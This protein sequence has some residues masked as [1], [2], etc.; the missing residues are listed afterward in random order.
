MIG[1]GK[2]NEITFEETIGDDWSRDLEVTESPLSHRSLF[3]LGLVVFLIGAIV[4]GRIL[5]LSFGDNKF[6]RARA[7]ANLNQVQKLSA[8][9]G[10]IV[11]RNGVVLAEDK[12]VFY[13][14]LEVK[15]FLR[16]KEYRQKTLDFVQQI[17]GIAEE[18][19]WKLIDDNNSGAV[20]GSIILGSE[21]SER[22][23]IE[24]ESLDLPTLNVVSGFGRLYK[25]GEIFSPIIGYTGP[26]TSDD[27]QDHPNLDG[28]DLVGKAGVEFYYDDY[29]RGVSGSVVKIRDALGN[30]LEEKKVKEPEIGQ[31]LKLTIDAELQEY[32]YNRFQSGLRSLGR[33]VGVG[34][35]INPQNGE[36]LSLINIPSFDNNVFINGTGEEK[37]KLLNAQNQPLFNRAIA[38]FYSPGSTIKPLVGVAALEENVIDKDKNIFSP[39]YLDVP[40]PYNPDNP[41]RFLDWRYQGYV[42]LSA[43]LAQSS[44][45]YFYIVGGGSPSMTLSK[46][47]IVDDGIRGLGIERL[48]IWWQK[49]GLGQVTGIDL[50]GEAS[51]FLPSVKYKE[52][53]TGSPWLLG[54]TYNV[55]IGQGDLLVTPIQLLSYIEAIANGGK[56]YRPRVAK[57]LVMPEITYNLSNSSDSISE[58]Q[59]GMIQAVETSMGTAKSLSWIPMQIAGKTGS[60]QVKN[61]AQENAFF[62]GYA[63]A[64]DGSL[65]NG[66]I[67][68][69][70]IAILVLVENSKEGS[71]NTLPIAGDVLNWYYVNRIENKD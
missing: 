68:K 17:L 21:L 40:N 30:I 18:D 43:A 67:L 42:D 34:L 6:Y 16:S 59:R 69:P 54:D 63:P 14:V 65:T 12:P 41:S 44:N 39:G 13:A 2:K 7:E 62:V 37:G 66:P 3:Y 52:D 19:V 49:F 56:I 1:K 11:D 71:L 55:S 60:A 4:F 31:P 64:S 27:L 10:L 25:N 32:F 20:S 22:Q 51:G 23:L 15:D 45:V 58:V 61:K 24:M 57:D 36:V 48:G 38:G 5:F 70:E 26:V 33:S 53:K 47:S 50:P 8:P 28:S 29:L 46:P 35:A 9:R